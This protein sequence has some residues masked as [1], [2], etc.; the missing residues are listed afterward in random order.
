[1]EEVLFVKAV[2]HGGLN[3]IS[4]KLCGMVLGLPAVSHASDGALGLRYSS[5]SALNQDTP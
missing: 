4:S 1:M 5:A 3:Q 2:C